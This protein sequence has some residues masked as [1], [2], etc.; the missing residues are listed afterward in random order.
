[1]QQATP[2][3]KMERFLNSLPR[4]ALPVR[5]ERYWSRCK[6]IANRSCKK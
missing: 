4:I 5:L 6:M 3:P 1:M 2:P